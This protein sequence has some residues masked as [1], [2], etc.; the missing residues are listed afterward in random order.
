VTSSSP[1]R[2]DRQS[3]AVPLGA[4]AA[5]CHQRKTDFTITFLATIMGD[6]AKQPPVDPVS[7]SRCT[8]CRSGY[9]PFTDD[10]CAISR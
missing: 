4:L 1:Y 10:P 6:P 2:S 7:L 3:I 5:Y 8:G 9:V